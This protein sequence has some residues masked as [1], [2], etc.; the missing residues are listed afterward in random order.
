[1]SGLIRVLI[2]DDH[3]SARAGVRDT[4]EADGFT[5]VGEAAN[6]TDAVDLAVE[7][8]PDLVLLD[9]HMPGSGIA[10]AHQI[11]ASCPECAVVMLTVSQDDEDL[12]QSLRAGAA[13]YLLKD[14]DPDRLGHALRGVLRGEAALPRTLVTKLVEQFQSRTRRRAPLLRRPE[15]AALTPK[16]WEVLEL[17][18]A[19]LSTAEVAARL[20]VTAV[21]VRSHV[22][23]ILKK[24]Q[25]PDREAALRLFAT[26][27]R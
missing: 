21:T 7:L 27:E 1:V 9:V 25:V 5:V 18:H 16:E 12:F 15:G 24:L 17:L 26:G 22:A 6:A 4:L 11:V 23:A 13:G 8:R 19:G 3:P 20:G 14:T 10:A 2:A